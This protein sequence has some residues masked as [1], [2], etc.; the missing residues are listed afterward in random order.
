VG[1]SFETDEVDVAIKGVL[2]EEVLPAALWWRW[3][4]Q[5]A[6][7]RVWWW[8]IGRWLVGWCGWTVS[9]LYL[10]MYRSIDL[11]LCTVMCGVRV[12]D[13]VCRWDDDDLRLA[14]KL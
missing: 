1:V 10:S 2:L 3:W 13:D 4:R 11:S 5:H 14:S 12:P 9:C 7:L 8:S 6:Q